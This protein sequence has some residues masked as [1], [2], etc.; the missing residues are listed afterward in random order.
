[1][2]GNQ[3]MNTTVLVISGLLILSVIVS[4]ST[5]PA[6]NLTDTIIVDKDG[7]GDYTTIAAAVKAAETGDTILVHQGLYEEDN[8]FINT[9]IT[10]TGQEI[11]TTIIQGDGT[12]TILNVNADNVKISYFTITGGGGGLGQNIDVAADNCVIS[13]NHIKLNDDVGIAIHDSSNTMINDNLISECPFAGIRI[14]NNNQSNSIKTNQIFD[15][16][17][18]IYVYNSQNQKIIQN[19]VSD[20]SKGIYLEECTNNIVIHNQLENNAQ[21][22]FVSYAKNN[23][24]TENNFVSN[25]EHAKFTTWLSPTGLQLSQWDANYWDDS[26]GSLPKWIPGVLFIRT[27]NPIGI[28]ISWGSVD[29]HPAQEPHQIDDR[30][31]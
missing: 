3:K 17:S 14:Y 29:W 25:D 28:F 21:G 23:L 31:I 9:S 6:L 27:Y 8:I 16:I 5:F 12:K 19:E 15:C 24:I 18:G 1:M 13:H 10:L 4:T 7:S 20:C 26:I 11:T 30:S 22:M 2:E